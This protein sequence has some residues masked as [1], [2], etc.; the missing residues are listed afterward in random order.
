MKKLISIMVIALLAAGF[1]VAGNNRAEAMNNESAAM[2]T[3]GI[4]LFGKPVMNAIAREIVY[5]G[6][7][8]AYAYPAHYRYGPPSRGYVEST[9]II[10]VEPRH[11]IHRHRG[12]AYR[13][14]YRDGWCRHEYLQGRDDSRRDHR[15]YR[16]DGND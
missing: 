5:P 11:K 6:Q 16:G 9:K 15:H 8:E 12:W 10:Y 3:A 4:V 7:H 1:L 14:G 2:L 13:K